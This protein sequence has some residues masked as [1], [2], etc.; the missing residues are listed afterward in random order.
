[1]R[2]LKVVSVVAIALAAIFASVAPAPAVAIYSSALGDGVGTLSCGGL[3]V[4]VDPRPS[5]WVPVVVGGRQWVSNANTGEGVGSVPGPANAVG[6]APGQQSLSFTYTIIG[7]LAP[8]NL[9]LSIW[10]DDTAGVSIDGAAWLIAPS[11]GPY[12]ACSTSA[13]GCS[14]GT[15]GLIATTLGIG[16]HTITFDVFQAGGA[17]TPFGLTFE[18]DLAATPEPAT[19]LLLGSALA[20]AGIASRRRLA[21]KA[22]QQ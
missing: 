12:P 14:A 10:A 15:E 5:P 2:I 17:G 7:L 8:T 3:C 20:A 13:I 18:G 6:L 9:N 11:A 4:N 1:M 19:I 22:Q 21:Q 16:N